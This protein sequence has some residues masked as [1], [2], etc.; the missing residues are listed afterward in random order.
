LNPVLGLCARLYARLYARLLFLAKRGQIID[1]RR[2]NHGY[3]A[4]YDR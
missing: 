2:N 4:Y 1:V 3:R